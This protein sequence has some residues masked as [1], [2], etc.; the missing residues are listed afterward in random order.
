MIIL[1]NY[2][3]KNVLFIL[4]SLFCIAATAKDEPRV[5]VLHR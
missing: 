2:L 3:L 5:F 4:L 1:K